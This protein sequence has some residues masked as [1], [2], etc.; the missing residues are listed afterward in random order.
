MQEREIKLANN[1]DKHRA[2][3]YTN[4]VKSIKMSQE[5]KLCAE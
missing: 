2:L 1:I 3:V 4:I 5:E